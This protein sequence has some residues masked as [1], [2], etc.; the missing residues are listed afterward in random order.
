[1]PLESIQLTSFYTTSSIYLQCNTYRKVAIAILSIRLIG[2]LRIVVV[3]VGKLELPRKFTYIYHILAIVNTIYYNIN[4]YIRSVQ[5]IYRET[6]IAIQLVY[7][8][9]NKPKK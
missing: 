2:T 6:I 5:I 3:L 8:Y 1:M 7:V 4:V 9:H